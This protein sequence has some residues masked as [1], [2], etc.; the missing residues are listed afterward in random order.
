MPISLDIDE[1]IQ[2]FVKLKFIKK[3]MSI[4]KQFIVTEQKQNTQRNGN[5]NKKHDK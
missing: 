2:L 1:I 3:N 4:L 5:K